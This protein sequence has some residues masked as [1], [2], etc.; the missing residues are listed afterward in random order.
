MKI[1]SYKELDVWKNG[2]EIVDLVYE[3][4]KRFPGEERYGIVAQMQRTAVSIPS[5]I[6]EGFARQHTKEYQQFCHIALGS[7]AELETQT[8]IAQRRGYVS[9]GQTTALLE[10]LDHESRMLMNLI[11]RLKQ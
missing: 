9:V 5:N 10:R 11:K 4:T 2:I 1:A 7:C 8:I 3:L 6:A